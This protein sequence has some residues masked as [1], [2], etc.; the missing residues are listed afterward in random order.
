MSGA[1]ILRFLLKISGKNL[2][3]GYKQVE[4]CM[5]ISLFKILINKNC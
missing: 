2:V 1:N 4:V 5:Y 3:V